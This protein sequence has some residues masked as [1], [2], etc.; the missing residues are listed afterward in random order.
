MKHRWRLGIV[1]CGRAYER[2]YAPALRLVPEFEPVGVVDPAGTPAGIARYGSVAEM[3]ASASIDCV[4]VLSPPQMHGEHVGI[5]LEHQ[6]PVLVEK[7]PALSVTDI[8]RWRAADGERLVTPAFS[9]RYWPQYSRP[10]PEVRRWKLMLQ[11]DPIAWGATH[12]SSPAVD[13]LPHIIDLARW[14]SGREIKETTVFRRGRDIAGDFAVGNDVHFVWEVGHGSRYVEQFEAD[15]HP[16]APRAARFRSIARTLGRRPGQDV[17]GAAL[18]LRDWAE[19]LSGGMP[20]S[21]PAF[22]DG[23][24]CVEV[25]QFV[26]QIVGIAP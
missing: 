21:L 12:E 17:E 13:L 24:R 20:R 6:R 23:A 18:L 19:R 3:C 2:L 26:Q 9:R 8:V 14:L 25:L 11:T 7:P 16:V 4:A 10:R 1:G 15:G 22:A 5:A